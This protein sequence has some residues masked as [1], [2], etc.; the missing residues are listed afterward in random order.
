[1]LVDITQL[2]ENHLHSLDIQMNKFGKHFNRFCKLQPYSCTSSPHRYAH[3]NEVQTKINDCLHQAQLHRL[4]T[5][6]SQMII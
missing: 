3:I 1:M 4:H 6:F 2:H 5:K